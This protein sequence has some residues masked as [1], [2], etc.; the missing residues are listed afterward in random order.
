[1]YFIQ[2]F[3]QDLDLILFQM[4]FIV[5]SLYIQKLFPSISAEEEAEY[6]QKLIALVNCVGQAGSQEKEW[7][8]RLMGGSLFSD[9]I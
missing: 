1:M 9:R 7:D 5:W 2:L 6:Q 8:K 4:T 3:A